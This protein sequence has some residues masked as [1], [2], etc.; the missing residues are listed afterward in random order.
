MDWKWKSKRFWELNQD[1]RSNK[2]WSCFCRVLIGWM[3]WRGRIEW[4]R[5]RWRILR[6]RW[7]NWLSK[8]RN[9]MKL[10]SLSLMLCRRRL[11]PCRLR[12]RINSKTIITNSKRNKQIGLRSLVK[13]WMLIGLT[14]PR[15]QLYFPGL[16]TFK[17]AIMR[18]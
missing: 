13:L 18:L 15:K 11:I 2:H 5:K 9:C 16:K 4:A 14:L 3:C 12:T 10:I 17:L 8:R 7:M 6:M 1:L